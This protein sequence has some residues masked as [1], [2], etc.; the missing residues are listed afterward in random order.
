MK[1]KTSDGKEQLAF[2]V[3]PELRHRL[4]VV[5]ALERRPA[6]S[7]MEELIRGYLEKHTEELAKGRK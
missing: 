5:A 7:I 1:T 2:R 4:K 3:D 6:G